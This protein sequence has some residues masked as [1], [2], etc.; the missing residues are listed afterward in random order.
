[1]ARHRVV[2]YMALL[3]LATATV[4]G[5]KWWVD[6]G[7]GTILVNALTLPTQN[8]RTV[9]L[10]ATRSSLGGVTAPNVYSFIA[11][12][13][14]E[15]AINAALAQRREEARSDEAVVLESA[16]VLVRPEGIGITLPF[17]TQRALSSAEF[18]GSVEMDVAPSAN[19]AYIELHP[20]AARVRLD[21]LRLGPWGFS[22]QE[23]TTRAAVG[24]LN[25]VVTI[26][27]RR[28]A[29]L[30]VPLTL[31]SI[32][33]IDIAKVIPGATVDGGGPL[34]VR[35][36]ADEMALVT[37][38]GG[39]H[40][41]G[42]L[43]TL[44][45]AEFESIVS[46]LE[47]IKAK[48]PNAPTAVRDC[49]ECGFGNGVGEYFACARRRAVCAARTRL[50]TPNT[51]LR[52]TA[53][54]A[55]VLSE[56]RNDPLRADIYDFFEPLLTPYGAV[57][58][59]P[60]GELTD[61][62]Y[63]TEIRAIL[64]EVLKRRGEVEDPATLPTGGTT[65]VAV[66]R[67]FLSQA[68]VTVL[69]P[70]MSVPLS[71]AIDDRTASLD[72][73]VSVGPAPDLRCTENARPC[74]S[75]FSFEAEPNRGCAGGCSTTSR[76]CIFG[77]C[78]D[79]PGIDLACEGARIDCNRLKEQEKAGWAI[80][81]GAAFAAWKARKDVCEA[82]KITEIAGCR[83]NQEWLNTWGGQTIGDLDGVATFSRGRANFRFDDVVVAEDLSSISVASTMGGG[84][85]VQAAVVYKPAD[86]IQGR[87][88]CVANWGGDLSA[89]VGLKPQPV[90]L[91][92]TLE[93]DPAGGILV[94]S[95]P[96]E[97]VVSTAPPPGIAL[98]KD[99]PQIAVV[100]PPVALAAGTPSLNLV[101]A[102]SLAISDS[103][104]IPIKGDERRFHEFA[105]EGT[106]RTLSVSLAP[107]TVLGA[108]R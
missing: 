64:Q 19:G 105:L 14:I 58:A 32:R 65:H 70:M 2:R 42:R 1:M 6:R 24:V 104:K 52:L 108:V 50:G 38:D 57:D 102:F 81:R 63:A 25:G 31:G 21:R 29:R 90:T 94:R 69:Q 87:I 83:L 62:Q 27:A 13:E 39:L 3:G 68:L 48:A 60:P 107:R 76:H 36:G 43:I 4:V 95:A 103:F 55:L 53:P 49:G 93:P 47:A 86:T 16:A 73:P 99:L 41:L 23:W 18:A 46:A 5:M 96:Q 72:A 106:G 26:A 9:A 98:L 101:A 56:F 15:A 66:S 80:R 37:G 30:S 7:V 44:S 35:L 28:I 71:I 84:A 12:Q 17:H 45:D 54:Q 92:A 59:D 88:V 33:S 34:S 75:E 82:L 91:V 67:R 79:V 74:E 11:Q 40:I 78:V 61:I 10:S 77:Q 100:C 85:H 51:D 20:I 22:S 89:D 97:L 8:A